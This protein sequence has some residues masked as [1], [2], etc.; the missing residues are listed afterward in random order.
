MKLRLALLVALVVLL[1][2]A[3]Q[4][5]ASEITL[6]VGPTG[7]YILGEVVPGIQAGGQVARDVV[8][9]NALR[10]MARDTRSAATDSPEYY[11]SITDFGTLPLAVGLGAVYGT[12]PD[13]S[14]GVGATTRRIALSSSFAYLLAAWDGPNGGAEA[15]YIGGIAAGTTLVLPRYAHP[16]PEF[17]KDHTTGLDVDPYLQDLVEGTK[18]QMTGWTLLNPTT[19][20]PDGGAT[21]ILLG[22][23]LIALGRVRRFLS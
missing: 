4:A 13:G 12:T 1:G 5:Q 18:Y 20:V 6:G 3:F 11:R 14:W 10:L 16:S 22:V 8:M 7:P 15:Y 19:Q 23:A 17:Y 21:A 2:T 9:V